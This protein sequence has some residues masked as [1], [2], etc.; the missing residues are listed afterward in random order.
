MNIILCLF[1]EISISHTLLYNLLGFS[2]SSY[3][4]TSAIQ[5]A[6]KHLLNNVAYA[7]RVRD[8][9][10]SLTEQIRLFPISHSLWCRKLAWKF[11][12]WAL[13]GNSNPFHRLHVV[14]WTCGVP[15]NEDFWN[16]VCWQIVHRKLL[17]VS[18]HV[19]FHPSHG[20]LFSCGR[21]TPVQ[22][23]GKKGKKGREEKKKLHVSFI[24]LACWI[25]TKNENSHMCFFGSL[26]F[27]H[28]HILLQTHCP[29]FCGGIL[30]LLGICSPN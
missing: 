20:I 3:P 2:S 5:Y 22:R 29:F 4:E 8:L 13:L 23:A 17:P 15:V 19:S 28:E 26:Q 21:N 1:F 9:A 10:L 25:I 6:F 7:S 16:L 14:K 24:F 12:A 18:L 11:W 30:I 27:F